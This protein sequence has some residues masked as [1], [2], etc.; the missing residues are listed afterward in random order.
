MFIKEELLWEIVDSATDVWNNIIWIS[1]SAPTAGSMKPL[2]I[3]RILLPLELF[4]G[5]DTSLAF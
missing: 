5:T 4:F 1:I 3:M 2:R